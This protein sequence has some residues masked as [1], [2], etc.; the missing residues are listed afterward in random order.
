[1]KDRGDEYRLRVGDYRVI[2]KVID[3]KPRILQIQRVLR[4]TSRTY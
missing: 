4:R 1:M 2:Y 3:G